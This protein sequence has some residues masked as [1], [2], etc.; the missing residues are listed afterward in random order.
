MTSTPSDVAFEAAFEA[1]RAALG[2]HDRQM[3]R[4]VE[5]V[6]H[7]VTRRCGERR[8]QLLVQMAS[9]HLSNH[10][11]M[12]EVAQIL[13][14]A[15]SGDARHTERVTRRVARGSVTTLH[16]CTEQAPCGQA[17]RESWAWQAEGILQIV[18]RVLLPALEGLAA[19]LRG[20]A[21]R[22]AMLTFA[23]P[24]LTATWPASA[25]RPPPTPPTPLGDVHVL[26]GPLGLLA[27]PRRHVGAGP[28]GLAA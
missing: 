10:L 27:P 15:A 13:R 7:A 25:A 11:L 8:A 4:R 23:A 5:R 26:G 21:L 16:V 19:E 6:T 3:R 20:P 9:H 28:E 18:R 24:Y 17:C 12:E 1:R 2:D 14:A 22:R